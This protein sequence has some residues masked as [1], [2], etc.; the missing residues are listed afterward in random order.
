MIRQVRQE[1]RIEIKRNFDNNEISE[2][3]KF[4]LEKELQEITDG[5]MEKIEKIGKRKEAELRSV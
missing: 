1:K 2:D 4:R 3:A 5:F